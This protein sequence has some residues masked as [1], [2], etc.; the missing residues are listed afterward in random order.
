[1]RNKI[2]FKSYK[3]DIEHDIDTGIL[4][5][6]KNAPIPN[7]QLME[8]LGI[9]ISS[10]DFSRILFMHHI[11]Q[12]IIDVLGVVMDF[13]TRWGNNLAL[14]STFRRMYEPYNR[15]RKLIGFDTFTGF[16]EL[17][18]KDGNS[19]LMSE[20]NVATTVDYQAYLEQIMSMKEK[21]NPLSHIKK[22]ELRAGE[23]C[24]ELPKYL[25]ENP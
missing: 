10:K 20:G 23:A 4:E 8:N 6:F 17:H 2:G 9:F 24:V 16:P 21:Q 3:S 1:M 14:F 15:H 7:D 5:A 25:S 13:G 12:K 11:Y 19:N 22:F 18:A